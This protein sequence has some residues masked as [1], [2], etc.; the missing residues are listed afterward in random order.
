[1]NRVSI[2][3]H[4]RACGDAV[5]QKGAGTAVTDLVARRC[6]AWLSHADSLNLTAPKVTLKHA[7][8]PAHCTINRACDITIQREGGTR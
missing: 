6:G 3:V 1:M 7:L 5:G 4:L 2:H 8:P